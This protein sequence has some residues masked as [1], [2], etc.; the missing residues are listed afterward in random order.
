MR[1][2]RLTAATLMILVAFGGPIAHGQP[3]GPAVGLLP[4][5]TKIPRSTGPG[6]PL[7][8]LLIANSRLTGDQNAVPDTVGE[9]LRNLPLVITAVCQNEGEK[10]RLSQVGL[11][12][13][14][15][16][17]NSDV[18]IVRAD[19]SGPPRSTLGLIDGQVLT[20]LQTALQRPTVLVRTTQLVLFELDAIVR[21][22]AGGPNQSRRMRHLIWINPDRGSLAMALW[23][24]DSSDGNAVAEQRWPIRLIAEG[25]VD[26]RPIYVDRGEFNYLLPTEKA[27]GLTRLPPGRSL[28]WN[29]CRR[30]LLTRG[31][32]DE[33][34]LRS[35]LSCLN[36]DLAGSNQPPDDR[37]GR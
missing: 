27:F 9:A 11:G 29:D 24:I 33:P 25:T 19:Q 30:E 20:R 31:Q 17:E 4:Q 18:R 37:P 34:S 22:D 35:T 15:S 10:H 5:N 16:D 26:V 3:A 13:G 8:T 12:Y 14:V 1:V 28:A 21:F 36:N 6:D 7:R 2:E 23:L 32:Y